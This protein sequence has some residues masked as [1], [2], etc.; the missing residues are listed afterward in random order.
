MAETRAG[1]GAAAAFRALLA[2]LEEIASR[3]TGVGQA[4][5]DGQEAAEGHRH[6]LHLLSAA[7]DFYLEGDP[8]RPVFTRMVSPGRKLLGDN[9][10]AVYHFAPIRGDRAYRVTGRRGDECYLS[11]TVHAASADG[12]I[13][14]VHERPVAD[15]NHLG[16]RTDADGHFSVTLAPD[17]PEGAPNAIRIPPEAVSVIVRHYFETETCVAADSARAY[18]LAIE[19]ALAPGPAPPW[20]EEAF[21]ARVGRALS[22]VR[23]ATLEM[24]EM[25]EGG[26]I[27]RTPNAMGQ[28][29]VFRQAGQAGWGAVDIAYAMGPYRVAEDEALLVEGRFPECLFAN[30]VLWNRFMQTFEYR[31]RPVSRNRAQTKLEPDGSFRM[32]IAHRDP[33]L[34][35]WLDT[36][37]HREGTL[38]WRFL[39]PKGEVLRPNCRL[40]PLASLGR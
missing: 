5:R 8:E 7:L 34:P 9:P 18:P 1:T 22:F 4:P 28:P 11:I 36:E 3:T 30:V 20:T 12:R 35:N 31:G 2:G 38:F 16:L 24:P 6:L 33:G 15:V 23:G 37:G 29:L 40:V 17:V 21:A 13:G 32:V 39:M 14:G 10:D 26:F 27:S 19:P 25:P